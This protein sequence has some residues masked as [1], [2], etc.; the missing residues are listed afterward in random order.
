[1]RLRL[2]LFEN[3]FVEGFNFR[4]RVWVDGVWVGLL[5]RRSGREVIS[6]HGAFE[7]YLS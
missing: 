2:L 6:L 7:P 1:M 5:E 3:L 4:T